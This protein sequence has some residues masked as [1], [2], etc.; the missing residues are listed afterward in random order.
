MTNDMITGSPSLEVVSADLGEIQKE[1]K[2]EEQPAIGAPSAML[3][4]EDQASKNAK[5]NFSPGAYN[6]LGQT[7]GSNEE[8]SAGI[9]PSR[10]QTT[11]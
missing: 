6:Q 10:G 2:A 5:A 8:R 7:F 3:P 1:L 9:N 4:V 11:K